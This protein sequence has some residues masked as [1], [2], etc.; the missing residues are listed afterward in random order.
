MPLRYIGRTTGFPS[1]TYDEIYPSEFVLPFLDTIPS[2]RRSP[3]TQKLIIDDLKQFSNVTERPDDPLLD[4]AIAHTTRKFML[5]APVRMKHLN[6]VFKVE[7]DIW[8]KSPGLPWTR[9]GVRTKGQIRDDPARI[10]DVRKFWHYVK[11]GEKQTFPDCCAFVRSH[12]CEQDDFKV[13]A[14]WG[15]PATVTFGEA[16]F[17]MPLIKGYQRLPVDNTP[18]AY[19]LETATGGM[20][21]LKTRFAKVG[22]HYAGLDFS[23]FDKTVPAWLIRTAFDILR[24][25]IDFTYYE[26]HGV[27]DA[28]RMIVMYERIVDYFINTT[29]QTAR[30][31]RFR[32]D[33]GIASG[34][35]FTQLVGSIVNCI[36]LYY[37]SLSTI[38]RMPF[39]SV[40]L[41]DD[42]FLSTSIPLSISDVSMCLSKFGVE[43]NMRKSQISQSIDEMRFLGY[44]INHAIPFKPADDLLSSLIF[45]EHPDDSWDAAA[46]RALGIY[47]A[48]FGVNRDVSEICWKMVNMAEFTLTFGRGFERMLKHIGYKELDIN[49]PVPV[50]FL[51]RL[52]VFC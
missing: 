26:D 2:K 51:R 17:A 31:L 39:D 32:K 49:L 52:S 29:V 50:E 40:F 15:Y 3:V 21:K 43:I 30:G 22:L 36:L 44:C 38:G 27:A 25:N 1:R 35:Y 42:S 7:S 10:R 34:S 19:G 23:K 45:P 9:Y 20:K 16:V 11:A 6:D 28:R 41:G 46:S 13:R 33:S 24:C 48:N 12:I 8:T 47:Y 14:V 5:P 18:I 37:A 4:L